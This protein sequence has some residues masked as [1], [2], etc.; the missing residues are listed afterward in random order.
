M[1]RSRQLL[2]SSTQLWLL[3]PWLLLLLNTL[4]LLTQMLLA[5]LLATL[6]LVLLLLGR[7]VTTHAFGRPWVRCGATL[8]VRLL[9]LLLLL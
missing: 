1:I 8:H 3:L 4:L 6:L 5:G 7:A 2:A 9:L